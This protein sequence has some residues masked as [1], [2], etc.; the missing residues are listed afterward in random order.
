MPIYENVNIVV[1]ARYYLSMGDF[2][3]SLGIFFAALVI[4]FKADLAVLGTV[5]YRKFNI[6]SNVVSQQ[7]TIHTCV[8]L[9]E[10]NTTFKTFL[11]SL[12]CFLYGAFSF[13]VPQ[14]DSAPDTILV[15]FVPP[16]L[17]PH[18]LYHNTSVFAWV[19]AAISPY[20]SF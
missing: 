4:L 9:S 7:T 2:I 8:T 12:K 18:H 1:S 5:C 10:V 6:Y 3:Q 19:S 15:Q 14:F 11:F 16:L 17:N 13:L 20:I